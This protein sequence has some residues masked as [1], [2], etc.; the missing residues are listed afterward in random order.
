MARRL[1]ET[2]VPYVQVNWSEYVETFTPN[3]DWGW[4]THIF[5]FELLQDQHCPI[6]DRAY[7]RCW[8][9]QRARPLKD[10][11]VVA[12]ANLTYPEDR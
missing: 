11:L 9:P 7:R 4:D 6:F 2:G 12:W 1:V 8:M 3:G 5:N 10:T